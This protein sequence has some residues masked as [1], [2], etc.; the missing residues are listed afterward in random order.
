MLND[1][2]NS[3]F[4]FDARLN[5]SKISLLEVAEILP[6]LRGM[7][8][9]FELSGRI[10]G[11]LDDLKGK[12]LQLSV[13]K[14]TSALFDFYLNDIANVKNMYL[15]IDMKRAETNFSDVTNF[16]LP[17]LSKIELIKFPEAFYDAGQLVYKGN[18]SGFLS[19]FVAFGTFT[20]QMGTL[21]TD[22]SV[23]PEKEGI[24]KYQGKIATTN[25][26]L[27]RLIQNNR[28]GILTFNGK[29]D[30]TNKKKKKKI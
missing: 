25:F 16:K 28:V 11:N 21:T 27:N 15:F 20:S 2:T 4:Q 19:D 12:N 14:N 13:G 5:N 22:L 3:E 6:V 8:Q 30:G 7:N 29:F 18:F 26:K 24:T 23:V 9:T 10:Y 17:N 1:T